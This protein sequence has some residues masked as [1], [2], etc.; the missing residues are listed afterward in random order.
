MNNTV[1]GSWRCLK[2]GAPGSRFRGVY[3]HRKRTQQD[4]SLAR[5]VVPVALGVILVLAGIAIGWVPGPGGFIG[6]FGV[7]LLATQ[8]RWLAKLL[9][10]TELRLRALWRV[11]WERRSVLA[12]VLIV[13][14]AAAIAAGAAYAV[15][16]LLLR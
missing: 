15:W 14:A 3:E 4:R 1:Q 10:W 5:R 11:A 8:F 6:I 2:E 12:R 7:A 16:R 9:D 13:V